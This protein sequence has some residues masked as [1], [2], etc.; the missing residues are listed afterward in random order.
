MTGYIKNIFTALIIFTSFSANAQ[1]TT[2]TFSKPD[3]VTP[4]KSLP[5]IPKGGNIFEK[6]RVHIFRKPPATRKQLKQEL[7]SLKTILTQN[8]KPETPPYKMD[9][10]RIEDSIIS[11]L[12][13]Y[14]SEPLK[15]PG[16]SST[17]QKP[18][19][20]LNKVSMPL[21]NAFAVTSGFGIR[22]HPI[23]G[24]IKAHNGIDIRASY[25]NVYAV[26]DGV[27]TEAGWDSKGGGNYIKI[28]HH[29]RFET[30]YLHL[31]SAYY[32]VGEKV[33]AGFIIAKS[34]NTGN[35][36][37]PHLH[38]SVKEYGKFINPLTFLKDLTLT[39]QLLAQHY[40]KPDLTNQRP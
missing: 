31:S 4:T 19:P 14:K 9:T 1:F 8:P 25:E 26:M 6:Q 36:T 7:D 22:R 29:G 18:L 32:K 35:S 12:K 20:A 3:P 28:R 17:L 11:I 13:Q 2:L 23:F 24:T 5:V 33:S 27:V 21:K 15:A 10:R 38:F 34:G 37:G 30:A 39:K 40:G 16:M